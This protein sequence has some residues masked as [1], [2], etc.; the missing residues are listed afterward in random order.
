M[1]DVFRGVIVELFVFEGF[2]Q[3]WGVEAEVDADV[4]VLLE[5]GVVE[6]G[7]EAEDSDGRGLG[8]PEGVECG[9][10]VVLVE[11]GIEVG[12]GDAVG[13]DFG[14]PEVPL[15]LELVGHVVVELLGGFGYGV[16]DDG[17]GG[18]FGAVVVDVE[19]LVG[20]GFVEADGVDAGCGDALV[21]TN[22]CELTHDRD[23]GVGEGFKAEV[24][25]P[26]T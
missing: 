19:A 11:V 17:T 10:V 21:S 7:A 15:H 9:V 3:P 13:I 6:L 14:G 18:V 2:G 8:L 23:E 22:E 24:G 16:F 1:L 5:A 26:E 25:E 12:V 4:A 20:G